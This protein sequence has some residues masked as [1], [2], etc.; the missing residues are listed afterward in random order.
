MQIIY[1]L[2]EGFSLLQQ[3]RTQSFLME[4][5][6][7]VL[8]Q[9]IFEIVGEVIGGIVTEGL[10]SLTFFAAN[11]KNPLKKSESVKIIKLDDSN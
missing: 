11:P 4:E 6:L 10:N 2:A 9:I 8:L 7:E 5:L 3:R 1:L